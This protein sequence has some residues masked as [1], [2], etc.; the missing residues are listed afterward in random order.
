MSNI[1]SNVMLVIKDM[2]DVGFSAMLLHMCLR[3]F[4]VHMRSGIS[5]SFPMPNFPPTEVQ[6][7]DKTHFQVIVTPCQDYEQASSCFERSH[8]S[9]RWHGL[10]WSFGVR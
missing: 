3:L 1:M 7:T 4:V 5:T 6:P 9:I 2:Q 10:S 8:H